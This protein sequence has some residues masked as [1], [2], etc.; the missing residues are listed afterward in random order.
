[1][2]DRVNVNACSMNSLIN[3]I[4]DQLPTGCY[5]NCFDDVNLKLALIP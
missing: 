4:V 3:C 2:L 1:M 5:G